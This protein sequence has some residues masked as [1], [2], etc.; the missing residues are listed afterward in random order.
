MK[1]T[2]YQENKQNFRNEL[3]SNNNNNNNNHMC[4]DAARWSIAERITAVHLFLDLSK[5]VKDKKLSPRTWQDR[6]QK[7]N[8]HSYY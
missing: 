6:S 4:P 5:E 7:R 1:K 8:K 2:K 3:N